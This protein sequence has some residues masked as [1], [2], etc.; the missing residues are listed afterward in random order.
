MKKAQLFT[1][2]FAG[3]N[4]YSF[5]F[6][7]PFLQDFEVIPLELPGRGKRMNER[8]L[9]DFDCAA[10][11]FYTQIKAKIKGG[12]FLIYGHSMGAYLALK[13]TALLEKINL[14]PVGLLVSG[15]PGPGI[16]SNKERYL[17][18]Q[19]A[20]IEALKEL[21]GVPSEIIEN[22]ELFDFFEPI[23]RA[24]FEIA[25][26]ENASKENIVNVPIYAMMGSTEESVEDIEN[27]KRFTNS[28]FEYNVLEGDHFF[29]HK[30]PEKIAQIIKNYFDS[31]PLMHYQ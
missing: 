7:L 26:K 20:F 11:D 22:K 12:P 21:G 10:Q 4:C 3:G 2:H 6:I 28:Q 25:E 17:L 24:D 5:Q 23:L 8:L 13:V 30:H 29:I 27:W 19:N 14:A 31:I 16:K 1:L 18:E 15:N 9:R